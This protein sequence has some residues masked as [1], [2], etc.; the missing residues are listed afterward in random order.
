MNFKT[1][2]FHDIYTELINK[3]H[4]QYLHYKN[5][6]MYNSPDK[7]P[8]NSSSIDSLLEQ[9]ANSIKN[10]LNVTASVIA[11][12]FKIH[13]YFNYKMNYNGLYLMDTIHKI[14]GFYFGNNSSER[15]I[16]A[17]ETQLIDID[18]TMLTEKVKC[19]TDLIQPM[20]NFITLFH[21]YEALK[22][23]KKLLE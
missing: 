10:H 21:K 13:S 20:D 15:R 4:D 8:Q 23:D 3:T 7:E 11:D 9:E 5:M 16:S 12:R 1:T 14:K 2:P 6:Q 22:Q 18:K 19:W 17:L